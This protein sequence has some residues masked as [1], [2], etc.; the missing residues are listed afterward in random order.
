MEGGRVEGEKGFLYTCFEKVMVLPCLDS[1]V[2]F[3]ERDI[4][5]VSTSSLSSLCIAC[6]QRV[7]KMCIH[8]L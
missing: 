6:C 4:I 7:V 1:S 3:L 8:L 2:C 5:P